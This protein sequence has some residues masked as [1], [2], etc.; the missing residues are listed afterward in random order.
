MHSL[1][2]LKFSGRFLV[3]FLLLGVGVCAAQ[4]SKNPQ[5]VKQGRQAFEDICAPCHGANA[6][7][8]RGPDL[9]IYA[10]AASDS[11]LFRVISHGVPGT[12]MPAFGRLS[13]EEIWD[14]VSFLRSLTPPPAGPIPGNPAAGEKL[15]WGEAGCGQCHTV[16]NRG[17]YI[18]PDL[19]RI[20]Q[21]RS[22]VYLR[23]SIVDPNADISPGYGTVS[24]VT[25]DGRQIE[26]V[27]RVFD[28]FN[29]K[30]VDLSGKVYSFRRSELASATRETSSLMPDAYGQIFTKAQLEDLVAYLASLRGGAPGPPPP[31]DTR[32]LGESQLTNAQNDP[33]AWL[34]YDRNYSGWRYSPLAQINAGTVATLRPQWVFQPQGATEAGRFETTPLVYNGTMYLTG[35]SNHAY[36]VDLQTGRQI[37]SYHED[38]PSGLSMCC[39]QE[40]RGFAALGNRLFKVNIQGELVALDALTGRVVWKSQMSDYRKGYTAT[41]APLVVKDMVLTG[42]A[43]GDFGVRGFVDAYDAQS[44]KRLWR[45]YTVPEPGDPASNTWPAGALPHAGGATWMT[46]TYDPELNLV[47]WGTGNP[48]PDYNGGVRSGDNLYTCSLVALD[49]DNGKLKWYYQFTPHDTHDWDA[50]ATPVLIDMP[51]HGQIVKALIEANRNGYFYALDRASGKLLVAK[52]YTKVTWAKGIGPDGRPILIPGPGNGPTTNG[53]IICPGMGGG[54]NWQPTAYSPQTGLYY[55]SSTGG[56]E[57]YYR[58]PPVYSQGKFYMAGTTHAIE[59]NSQK[60]AIIAVDPTTGDIKWKFGLV[61]APGAAGLLATAGGLVFTGDPQGYVYALDAHTGKPLWHFR[62]GGHIRTGPISY[63]SN[64]KQYVTF[65]T[66]DVVLSF[67]LP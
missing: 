53:N 19:S 49:P 8:A 56:C 21:E 62:T 11:D 15:F 7:G 61:S 3:A 40:N 1:A 9:M 44:G 22:L 57:I 6:Q 4:V 58:T 17:K 35:S 41:A 30:L 60:G 67:A 37:W 47:Y 50:I 14:V 32:T 26:G 36:A 63:E 13:A 39:N 18:G 29:V 65:V 66:G 12:E 43:G 51:F 16:G 23:Q 38:A 10:R 48:G 31:I 28:N 45:F 25:R 52:P 54:H 33:S 27:E 2:R 46:G 5:Q 24:V 64:G 59:E 20:G 42:M 34:M 55:F